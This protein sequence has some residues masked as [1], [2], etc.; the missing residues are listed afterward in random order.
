VLP[1]DT[2]ATWRDSFV[3][4]SCTIHSSG[5]I[6]IHIIIPHIHTHL[7]TPRARAYTHTHTHTRHYLYII[8]SSIS[9]I[10]F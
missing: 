5:D 9:V 1:S 6:L 2:C 8:N 7:H 10:S 3:I 4:I